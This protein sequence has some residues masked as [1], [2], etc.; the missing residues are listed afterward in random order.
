MSRTRRGVGLKLRRV[1][2]RTQREGGPRRARGGIIGAGARRVD[3]RDNGGVTTGDC[4]SWALAWRSRRVVLWSGEKGM[5]IQRSAS[6]P[7]ALE[8]LHRRSS[9]ERRTSHKKAMVAHGRLI[10]IVRTSLACHTVSGPFGLETCNG[11]PIIPW[12]RR[13]LGNL[14]TAV[15]TRSRNRKGRP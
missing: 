10:K 15:H 13:I 5:L 12:S 4:E 1:Q 3:I 14:G 11:R 2:P 6:G 8:R 9:N 7:P